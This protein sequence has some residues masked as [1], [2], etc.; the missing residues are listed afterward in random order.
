MKRVSSSAGRGGFYPIGARARKSSRTLSLRE[1]L[2]SAAARAAA[3]A[4]T[5]QL[6][7]S[8]VPP[9]GAAIGNRPCPAYCRE[10][11]IAREQGGRDD[12]A[13]RGRKPDARAGAVPRS[14]SATA[15]STALAWNSSIEEAAASR[16]ASAQMRRRRR[17]HD[18]AGAHQAGEDDQHAMGLSIAVISCAPRAGAPW[19]RAVPACRRRCARRSPAPPEKRRDV[20]PAAAVVSGDALLQLGRL[21]LIGL[22]EHDLIAHG[23]LVE[24]LETS[25]STSLRPWRA[26]IST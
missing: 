24:R 17:Q 18:A 5:S 8:S 11:Q 10:R 7:I 2:R 16:A 25:R 13:E 12:E 6:T 23:G 19:P 1:K 26:S 4:S 22:G 14:A 21:H 20:W 9:V 3:S 15:P